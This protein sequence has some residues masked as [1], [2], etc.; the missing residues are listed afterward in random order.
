[1]NWFKLERL[2]IAEARAMA[3]TDVIVEEWAVKEVAQ[4]EKG[5][6]RV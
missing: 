2:A 1:L 5:V 6:V 3:A 4:R